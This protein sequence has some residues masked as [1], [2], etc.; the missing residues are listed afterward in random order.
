ML[1]T[2]RLLLMVRPAIPTSGNKRHAMNSER[3]TKYP[4]TP[5]LP[6]SPGG[7]SDDSYHLESVVWDA[8]NLRESGRTALIGL[9]HDYNARTRIVAFATPPPELQRRNRSRNHSI[10]SAVLDRQLEK[11][12]WPFAWE[13]HRVETI[14]A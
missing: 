2:Q 4:R 8:T 6:W 5:H 7:S 14:Y 9:G 11:F 10:P 3:C 1:P 12:E 13:A